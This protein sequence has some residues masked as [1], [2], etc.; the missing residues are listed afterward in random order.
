[1]SRL[2]IPKEYI[3]ATMKYVENKLDS[4]PGYRIAARKGVLKIISSHPRSEYMID[5]P[6]GRS[7]MPIVRERERLIGMRHDLICNWRDLYS[8]NIDLDT[9]ELNNVMSIMGDDLWYR[10][11]ADCNQYQKTDEL[12]H[13]GI[14]LRSRGEMLVGEILDRLGLEYIYEPEIIIS[15]KKYSPDF[16]VHVPAFCCCF[17]IEYMGCMD[18]YGYV[19]KNKAKI[20]SY[21]HAGL[22]PGR[23]LIF[24][25]A[26]ANSAPTFDAIHNSI[27]SLLANL[28][29]IHVKRS[30]S[31]RKRT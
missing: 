4:L 22:F 18:E 28:C 19:E 26:N 1:M 9:L 27:V 11:R 12:F 30:E 20:G 21:L 2:P 7:L 29:S 8:E 15:G 24:L 31:N 16:V 5:R 6:Q 23:D 10:L 25:C 3:L 13:N 17:I 14:Q